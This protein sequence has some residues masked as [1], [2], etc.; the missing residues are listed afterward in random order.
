[1]Q[2]YGQLRDEEQG[3]D[4]SEDD[5]LAKIKALVHTLKV[6]YA[7]AEKWLKGYYDGEI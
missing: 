5:A 1:M 6:D 3:S 4:L 7:E 2:H